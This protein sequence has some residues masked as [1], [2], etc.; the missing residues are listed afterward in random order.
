MESACTKTVAARGH[1]S[2]VASRLSEVDQT[3]L[4]GSAGHERHR[5]RERPAPW[6]R[7][8]G[9]FRYRWRRRRWAGRPAVGRVR[10]DGGQSR[11]AARRL[12]RRRHS[13]KRSVNPP[14]RGFAC[15]CA[16]PPSSVSRIVSR[17]IDA[18]PVDV[19]LG[20]GHLT[21]DRVAWGARRARRSGRCPG[22]GSWLRGGHPRRCADRDGLQPAVC[23]DDVD[24]Y[25]QCVRHLE[26]IGG[27][28]G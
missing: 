3:R 19:D 6:F 9:S 18:A 1:A 26:Q 12:D 15:R 27:G 2:T 13:E 23:A 20:Q 4:V 11:H 24:G 17:P 28:R 14:E 25:L 7:H 22:T 16:N 5:R 21:G 10:D 8:R